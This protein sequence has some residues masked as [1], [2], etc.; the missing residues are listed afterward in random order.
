MRFQLVVAGVS[1]G[2]GW[3]GG[4][5]GEGREGQGRG[6][7]KSGQSRQSGGRLI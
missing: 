2:R 6:G 1:G 4:R 7:L 5:E 3:R